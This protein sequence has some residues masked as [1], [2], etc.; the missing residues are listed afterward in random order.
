MTF[1]V[2]AGSFQRLC[3]AQ[4]TYFRSRFTDREP[5]HHARKPAESA[6]MHILLIHNP[7]AGAGHPS[8]AELMDLL[9]SVDTGAEYRSIRNGTYRDTLRQLVSTDVVVVAGGDGTVNK[10]ARELV[11]SGIPLAIIP[12]GTANNIASTL[13]VIKKADQVVAGLE[14][15]RAIPFDVGRV[16]G[17][18]QERYF[19]EGLG[20]GVVAEMMREVDAI[21][22]SGTE[23][24]EDEKQLAREKLVQVTRRDPPTRVDLTL[25]G[26]DF[27]G[28][29]IL[30]EVLN[31][32]S[33]A[34]NLDLSPC[35]DPSDA[36]L[37]VVLV[38][39]SERR[40]ME[41]YVEAGLAGRPSAPGF[42][43][44]RARQIQ[45]AWRGAPLHVDDWYYPEHGM[46]AGNMR[47]EVAVL[48][49]AV[50]FLVS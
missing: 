29:Y 36:I 31:T 21:K 20:V 40:K 11:S 13:G 15:A 25:D 37:D 17:T 45:M 22:H 26:R 50:E 16:S 27:S 5:E 32:R 33:I 49:S 1:L 9:R 23:K 42:V 47:V 14:V 3:D 6:F 24:V 2:N 43:T 48:P 35:A 41:D 18:V 46:S 7:A 8:Q 39:E 30:V 4:L 12:L 34:S 19:L 28:E 38:S 44:H 10:V